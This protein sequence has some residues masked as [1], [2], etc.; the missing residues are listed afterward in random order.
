MNSTEKE[1]D[2]LEDPENWDFDAIQIQ[3]PVKDPTAVVS[4]KLNRDEFD[5]VATA[6]RRR[7]MSVTEFIKVAALRI[8]ASSDSGSNAHSE[9][10]N[11]LSFDASESAQS[12]PR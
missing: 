12:H 3:P 7:G 6:A 11:G 2:E 5:L 8:S 4:V 10:G 1:I 9:A